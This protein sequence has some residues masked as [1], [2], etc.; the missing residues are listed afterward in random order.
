MWPVQGQA[1]SPTWGSLSNLCW[2]RRFPPRDRSWFSRDQ[3]LTHLLVHAI[4]ST[5]D[6]RPFFRSEEIRNEIHA[7]I[8]APQRVGR[9]FRA[10]RLRSLHPG[11]KRLG[12][13]VRP[14]RGHWCLDIFAA[15]PMLGKCPT[16]RPRA[17]PG[18]A[19]GKE[20]KWPPSAESATKQ[21]N[22]R[23]LLIR[24]TILAKICFRVR[25]RLVVVLEWHTGNIKGGASA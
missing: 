24:A 9:P 20:T 17:K 8:K 25:V 2:Q 5:K 1:R 12:Y 16:S 4:F 14:L 18:E 21:R 3:S 11:L 10:C 6:R 13:S 15:E 19:L 7:Y 22:E 23:L